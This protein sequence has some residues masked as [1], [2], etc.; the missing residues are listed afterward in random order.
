MAT[1][2]TTETLH[3]TD[4]IILQALPPKAVLKGSND[5]ERPFA[6]AP[7]LEPARSSNDPLPPEDAF[8]AKV[9]WN[10][11]PINKYRVLS[12]FWSF[13]VL[14][15]NDGSYGALVP[16]FES[17][18]NLTYTV[19]SLIFLSPF[20][21]YTMAALAN[22]AIHIRFGQRGVGIIAPL[23]RLIPYLVITFHPPYPVLVVMYILVGFGN[24][25]VDA[26]WSAWIGNMANSHEVS[27]VLQACYALGATVAPLITTAI[28]SHSRG[29]WWTFYYIMVSV[30]ALELGVGTTTFWTQ[31]GAVY[32]SEN[33]HQKAGENATS[34]R[35]REALKS[36]LTWFFSLFIFLYVGTEVSIGGWIVVFMTKVRNASTFAGSATATGF[37]GGMTVGR[38]VL[39]FVTSRI[40]G[41]RAM[42][43]YLGLAIAIELVF[44]LVPNM[45]VTAVASALLGMILGPIYPTAVVLMT[46][47]LPR[48][49]HISAIGFAT[50]IGGSGSAALPFAVGA[51]A[52]A[53]G[54]KTL[55]PIVLA[56]CVVMLIVW[57][58]LQQHR[59]KDK[60]VGVNLAVF[61]RL[62][63]RAKKMLN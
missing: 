24:G 16:Q 36:K 2:T 5:S 6:N 48:S 62:G 1:T 23:F 25:I 17:Y 26:A 55:Q 61:K 10:S 50:A 29:G 58:F 63:E 31:T 35:T 54:V 15:M 41:F 3:S 49:L 13:F 11:P 18:Y 57:L 60:E 27:G 21:G 42:L 20:A 34:G 43:L 22:S 30:S 37:W 46:T 7:I 28:S 53:K 9:K 14:G 39:G 44:W 19:V 52:Q 8:E 47:V 56:C 59:P 38:L 12:T 32:L 33:P 40:G 45:V 51:I 4:E